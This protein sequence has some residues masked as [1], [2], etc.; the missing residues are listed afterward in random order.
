MDDNFIIRMRDTAYD[1]VGPFSSQAQLVAWGEANQA[2][3]EDDPRWQSI[4]LAD[5]GAVPRV[6]AP[7]DAAP[8]PTSEQ[9][10]A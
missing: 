2:A 4:Y 8:W 6:S 10:S 3:S 7:A 9:R 5:P 1:L